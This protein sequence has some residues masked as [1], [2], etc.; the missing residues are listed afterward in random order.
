MRTGASELCWPGRVRVRVGRSGVSRDTPRPFA[1]YR[2][3]VRVRMRQFAPDRLHL[4]SGAIPRRWGARDGR[5]L[6]NEYDGIEVESLFICYKNVYKI[7]MTN[8]KVI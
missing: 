8:Q 6:W 2:K 4:Q 1:R 5:C 3:G 7:F